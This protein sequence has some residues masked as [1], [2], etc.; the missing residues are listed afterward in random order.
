MMMPHL[1]VVAA[2]QLDFSVVL[3]KDAKLRSSPFIHLF[4]PKFSFLLLLAFKTQ[5]LAAG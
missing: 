5:F 4:S 3:I 1:R 2:S